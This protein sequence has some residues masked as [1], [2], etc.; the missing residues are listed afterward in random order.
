MQLYKLTKEYENLAILAADAADPAEGQAF[1][2]TLEGLA[3]E[4][5]AKV[6]NCAAVVK[7]IEGERDAADGERKRLAARVASLDNACDRL[8]AYMQSGMETARL[9][10]I[11]GELFTVAIQNNPPRV[12]VDNEAA[13]PPEYKKIVT[14]IQAAEISKAL[15]SGIEVIGAHLE[16]SRSLRIR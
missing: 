8:K 7:T 14:T 1:T 12:K 11:K 9:E 15:K 16:Q 2:D 10:K 6:L 3:G 4:I 13:I 5:E